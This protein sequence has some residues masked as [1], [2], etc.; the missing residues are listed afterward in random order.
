MP[1]FSQ[2]RSRP[3]PR[4]DGGRIAFGEVNCAKK[5]LYVGEMTPVEI[6]YYFD[7]RYPVQIRGAVNFESEGILVERFL[8]P[9]EGREERDGILYNVLTFRSLL[10]AVK[11][12]SIDIP[13]AKLETQ[14]QMPGA[15]PPGFDD[16]VFQQLLG[17]RAAFGQTRDLTVTTA[18]LHL[19]V[20]S[21]PKEGRPASFAGAVGQFDI[22][23]VVSN[24]RPAPGDPANLVVK[25]GG[26][27]NF[28]G[29]GAPILKE[30]EGWRTYPPTDKF[31]SSDELS[32]TGVKSFDFTLLAQQPRNASPVCEFSYFDPTVAKYV[33]RTTEPLP[34]TAIP[35]SSS[36]T[37]A[38]TAAGG[39]AR[40]TGGGPSAS[41]SPRATP[42]A[43]YPL[44]GSTLRSWETPVRRPEFLIASL[45]MLVATGSLAGILWW[46]DL[47]AR[48]GTAAMRRRKRLAELLLVAGSERS[49]GG[50]AYDAAVEYAG[51]IAPPS[52]ARDA[53]IASL[54]GRRD[55]LKYGT[56]GSVPLSASERETLLETLRSLAPR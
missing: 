45:S 39:S 31:D 38:G 8:E 56:G 37:A 52:E 35:G 34:L 14:I 50:A 48:G 41:P 46:L 44:P 11:P 49:E 23:A 25:I 27:G 10:S 28:K 33:T 51:L 4:Q 32:Y 7:A 43:G 24:P 18:P 22:D 47:Q 26:K 2:P 5:S 15:L 16:P 29:M 6:R 30:T 12:G 42:G 17:G 40:S 53:S 36:A 13:P 9:K 55:L 54:V 3:Q 1:G 21:L 20:L 19:D